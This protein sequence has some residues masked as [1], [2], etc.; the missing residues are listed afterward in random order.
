[1][2][3]LIPLLPE[4]NHQY[5]DCRPCSECCWV[6][7]LAVG[8]IDPHSKSLGQPCN[9]LASG[10]CRIHAQRFELCRRFQCTWLSDSKWNDS[11]R[12]DLSGLLCLREW[13]DEQVPAAIVYELRDGVIGSP[14]AVEILSEL[15]RTTVSVTVIGRDDS[16][17]RLVGAWKPDEA[18]NFVTLGQIREKS[19]A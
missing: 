7:P 10:G 15:C 4:R 18:K 12:P 6:L 14:E 13:I 11:W 2:P 5:R 9:R 17:Q 1:M 8:H 16:R 19:A 3:D